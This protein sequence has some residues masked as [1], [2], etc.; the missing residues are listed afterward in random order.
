MVLWIFIKFGSKM[1]KMTFSKLGASF[2][3]T[4]Y[5]VTYSHFIDNTKGNTILLS[6][7]SQ[8]LLVPGKGT[9]RP[10]KWDYPYLWPPHDCSHSVIT[11]HLQDSP[12]YYW[13]DQFCMHRRCQKLI[14]A[15]I[16]WDFPN[17]P[18]GLALTIKRVSAAAFL[19]IMLRSYPVLFTGQ[20]IHGHYYFRH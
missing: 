11:S 16:P 15:A 14:G 10:I 13:Q 4:W 3:I 20:Q 9:R 17:R 12:L 6:E 1:T 7:H 19:G 8:R 18:L 5:V 2:Y